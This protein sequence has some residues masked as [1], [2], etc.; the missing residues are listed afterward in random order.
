MG[1]P[2]Q[3]VEGWETEM[4]E[5]GKAERENKEERIIVKREMRWEMKG[6]ARGVKGFALACRNHAL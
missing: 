1:G 6:H 3:G 5:G 4:D 2:G